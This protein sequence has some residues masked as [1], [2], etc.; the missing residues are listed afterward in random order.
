[1]PLQL[2][3]IGLS[4]CSFSTLTSETVTPQ[5][6]N[7]MTGSALRKTTYKG[8]EIIENEDIY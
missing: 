8:E 3:L 4:G 6:F 7:R 5:I 1:L 2:S